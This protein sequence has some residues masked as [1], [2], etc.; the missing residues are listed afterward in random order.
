MIRRPASARWGPERSCGQ[1]NRAR[2]AIRLVFTPCPFV[3]QTVPHHK[4]DAY[5]FLLLLAHVQGGVRSLV[6][7]LVIY[8]QTCRMLGV[9]VDYD[10]SKNLPRRRSLLIALTGHQLLSAKSFRAA[11]LTPGATMQGC[12]LQH[13]GFP[14]ASQQKPIVRAA[15][16]ACTAPT[17]ASAQ[18]AETRS[19]DPAVGPDCAVADVCL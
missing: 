2:K 13:R 17:K 19:V 7:C 10:F 9:S 12:F 11:G 1:S 8:M 15:R 3:Q 5:T 18:V 14:A 6:P 4:R 16:R